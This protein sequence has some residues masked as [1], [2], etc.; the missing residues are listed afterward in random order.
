M[1]KLDEL[2]LTETIVIFTSDNGGVDTYFDQSPLRYGKGSPYEGRIRVP[3]IVRWPKAIAKGKVNTTAIH[4]IDFYPTLLEMAGIA[5][6]LR[7]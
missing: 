4:A 3:F 2:G 1:D 6:R 7:L 5:I